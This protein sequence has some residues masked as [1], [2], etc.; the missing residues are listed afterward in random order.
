MMKS[1][2]F[3]LLATFASVDAATQV[4][5]LEFGQG[6]TVRRAS[7]QNAETTAEGV[8]S[9]W[10]S[11]HYQRS[12]SLQH[13]GMPVVPD[14]FR[15]PDA[16]IVISI[17]GNSVDL[18]TLPGLASI[19][20]SENAVGVMEVPGSHSQAM[21]D[22]ILDITEAS[23]ETLAQSVKDHAKK[24]GLSGIKVFVDT[25]SVHAVDRQ[26]VDVM[27]EL[28]ASAQSSEKSVVVHLV[29]EEDPTVSRQRRLED[30]NQNG[31]NDDKEFNGYYG[32]AYMNQYGEW[33]TPYKTMFQIQYFNVVTWTAIGLVFL[34]FYTIFL[35]AYMPLEPDTLLFGESAKFVGD[36]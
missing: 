18:S 11:L 21:L 2:V 19:F 8:T 27:S 15:Q 23:V 6:G 31:E 17:S 22:K 24:T 7:G 9:F 10:S 33:V 30:Q 20:E 13:A 35:M 1:I 34:L 25:V 5:V 4:A 36:E 29:I 12:S 3:S 32:Y 14:L 16:G 28:K 26:L